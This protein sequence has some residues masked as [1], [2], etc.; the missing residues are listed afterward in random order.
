M[1]NAS[2]KV[3]ALQ[4]AIETHK[5]GVDCKDQDSRLDPKIVLDTAKDFYDWLSSVL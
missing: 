5:H 2:L 3:T 1:E 4:L